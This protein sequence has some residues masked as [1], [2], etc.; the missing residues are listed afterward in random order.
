MRRRGPPRPSWTL[1]KVSL[2]LAL[3]LM[4]CSLFVCKEVRSPAELGH[5]ALGLPIPF[6]TLDASGYAPAEYP[7]CFGFGNPHADVMRLRPLA[8]VAN[9]ALL[10]LALML[11][12]RLVRPPP[13]RGGPA[14][15]EEGTPR[16]PEEHPPR[17][18]G[19]DPTER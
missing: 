14:G 3:I 6:V 16:A 15:P 9:L 4:T 19:R 5:V 1:C 8:A 13:G 17:V 18:G 2:R 11:A 7:R 10:T 12:A